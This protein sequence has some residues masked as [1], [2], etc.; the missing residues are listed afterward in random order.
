MGRDLRPCHA[1]APYAISTGTTCTVCLTCVTHPSRCYTP[2][3][4][5]LDVTTRTVSNDAT[6]WLWNFGTVV[7]SRESLSSTH[8]QVKLPCFTTYA[9]CRMELHPSIPQ[10]HARG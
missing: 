9:L 7:P 4:A 10:W 2:T 1:L 6:P 3:P 8:S 5:E